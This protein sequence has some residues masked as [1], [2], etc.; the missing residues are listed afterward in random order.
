LSALRWQ[1]KSFFKKIILQKVEYSA[2][3]HSRLVLLP[4]SL[5][6]LVWVLYLQL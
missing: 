4:V 2:D 5:V 6:A 1:Q 3:A